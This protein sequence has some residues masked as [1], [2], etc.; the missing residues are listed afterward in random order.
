[1][2]ASSPTMLLFKFCPTPTGFVEAAARGL[3]SAE[4]RDAIDSWEERSIF[5]AES[6]S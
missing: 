1:M 6:R 2:Y 5:S 4:A 3:Y